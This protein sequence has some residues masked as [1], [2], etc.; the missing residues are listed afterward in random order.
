MWGGNYAST[1]IRLPLAYR[2]WHSAVI[3]TEL[4]ATYLS[5]GLEEC[6]LSRDQSGEGALVHISGLPIDLD[7]E[8]CA[9]NLRSY[10]TQM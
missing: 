1:L 7:G 8:P 3:D 9:R 10:G 6:I 5:L 4:L 2:S